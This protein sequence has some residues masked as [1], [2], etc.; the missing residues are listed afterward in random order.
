M[1][2]TSA[3]DCDTKLNDSPPNMHADRS[4]CLKTA[5]RSAPTVRLYFVRYVCSYLDQVPTQVMFGVDLVQVWG[6]LAKLNVWTSFE[7]TWALSCST[8]E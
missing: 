6:L 4:R 1:S 2:L 5:M 3:D 7:S 8:Q